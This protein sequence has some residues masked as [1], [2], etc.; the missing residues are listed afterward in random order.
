M[1]PERTDTERVLLVEDNPHDVR[2]AREAIAEADSS[3]ELDVV[4]DGIAAIDYLFSRG[5][6]ADATTPAFV[7]LDYNLPKRNGA[8][9]LAAVKSDDIL[10]RVPITIFT[11]SDSKD[12]VVRMYDLHAN[13][14]V[15]KPETV[16][17]FVSIIDHLESFW[18][19]TVTLPP[20][21]R[22]EH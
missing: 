14:Y 5:E 18:L 17:Q 11:T 15:T 6:Y 10:R 3:I 21:R 7:L 1:T 9:V 4:T 20:V 22:H 16:D 13:A 12:D 8:E 19:S 2:L